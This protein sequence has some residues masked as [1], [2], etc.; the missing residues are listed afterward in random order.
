[1]KLNTVRKR[2]DFLESYKSNTYVCNDAFVLKFL[3]KKDIKC[4]K[5]GFVVSKKNGNAVTRNKIKRRLRSIVS[6]EI[7]KF[8]MSGYYIFI[9]RKLISNMEFK[10]LRQKVSLGL[11]ELSKTVH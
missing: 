8:N 2:R 9:A 5:V 3:P 4:F 7:H 1:M 6:Q 10:I 11:D